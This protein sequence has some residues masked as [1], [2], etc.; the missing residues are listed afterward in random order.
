MDCYKLILKSDSDILLRDDLS[1]V[2]RVV[3]TACEVEGSQELAVY[4]CPWGRGV[5]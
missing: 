3:L 4:A 1:V 2:V 5:N